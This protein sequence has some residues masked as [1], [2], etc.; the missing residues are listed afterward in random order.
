MSVRE[1]TPDA[2]TASST[3]SSDTDPSA[4]SASSTIYTIYTPPSDIEPI[5]DVTQEEVER[6]HAND[7]EPVAELPATASQ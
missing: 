2:D 3:T 4:R 7:N 1:A 5:A 6:T